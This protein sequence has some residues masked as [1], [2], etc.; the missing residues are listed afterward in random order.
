MGF[1][2]GSVHF[3]QHAQSAPAHLWPYPAKLHETSDTGVEPIMVVHRLIANSRCLDA[4]CVSTAWAPNVQPQLRRWRKRR[5]EWAYKE[6]LELGS[7]VELEWTHEKVMVRETLLQQRR[8]QESLVVEEQRL[9]DVACP[10]FLRVG[11]LDQ[12]GDS[13][14]KRI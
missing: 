8:R 9:S 14:K 7:K 13:E 3:F 4:R 10:T 5:G 1:L 11:Y 12:P 2:P 6:W